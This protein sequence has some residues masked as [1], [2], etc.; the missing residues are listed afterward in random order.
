MLLSYLLLKTSKCL[1]IIFLNDGER[2]IY[3]HKNRHF[4]NLPTNVRVF[5]NLKIHNECTKFWLDSNASFATIY[6]TI[7]FEFIIVYYIIEFRSSILFYYCERRI[8]RLIAISFVITSSSTKNIILLFKKLK[9]LQQCDKLWYIII[10]NYRNFF[11]FLIRLTSFLNYSRLSIPTPKIYLI[12]F[13]IFRYYFVLHLD[14]T[15]S[16]I[17]EKM[18]Y[19]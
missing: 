10:F 18:K 8:A 7:K 6:Y 4:F 2:K 5:L 12:S 14:D 16:W 1:N 9:Y 13:N 3:K 17:L 15:S 19:L 11:A